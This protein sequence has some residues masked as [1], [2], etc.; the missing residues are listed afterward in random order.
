MEALRKSRSSLTAETSGVQ[1]SEVKENEEV[2]G[3]NNEL[4]IVTEPDDSSVRNS[5]NSVV[6]EECEVSEA[7]SQKHEHVGLESTESSDNIS[8]YLDKE[9]RSPVKETVLKT[10]DASNDNAEYEVIEQNPAT[11][12]SNKKKRKASVE[13]SYSKIKFEEKSPASQ[14]KEVAALKLLTK[15]LKMKQDLKNKQAEQQQFSSDT[16]EDDENKLKE[17]Q[18]IEENRKEEELTII[19]NEAKSEVD[20]LQD[21]KENFKETT[22][23]SNIDLKVEIKNSDS[24]IITNLEEGA[25]PVE[26]ISDE[27]TVLKKSLGH[28][29][30]DSS[31]NKIE[32]RRDEAEHSG[33]ETQEEGDGGGNKK[34]CKIRRT[35]TKT[36]AI[37]RQQLQQKK[38]VKKDP[39]NVKPVYIYIPLKPPEEEDLPACQNE[40]VADSPE[41]P[42]KNDVQ[43]IILTAPS[44]DEVLDYHSSDVPETPSSENKMF[45]E[46]KV[47]EL[48]KIAKEAVNEVDPSSTSQKLNTVAEETL[49]ETLPTTDEP[50]TEPTT[51]ETHSDNIEDELKPVQ[52]ETTTDTRKIQDEND[53]GVKITVDVED[54][55]N[56]TFTKKNDR[57]H[58]RK[59]KSSDKIKDSNKSGSYED[60]APPNLPQTSSEPG[61]EKDATDLLEHDVSH[62]MN[63]EEQVDVNKSINSH[64]DNQ[65]D[66]SKMSDHEY[67]P[68]NPPPDIQIVVSPTPT[69]NALEGISPLQS[70]DKYPDVLY[71]KNDL[72]LDDKQSHIQKTDPYPVSQSDTI[73]NT[74][75][76]PTSN[77]EPTPDTI[78]SPNKFQ[79]SWKQTTNNFK[80]R[81][82]NMK[83]QQPPAPDD[84]SKPKS[85][86]FKFERPKFNLA[87][88]FPDRSKINLPSLPSF[89]LPRRNSAKRSLKE[90]QQSTESNVS[91]SKKKSFDFSTYPRIFKK[92]SKPADE[93]KT[94]LDLATD[95][96]LIQQENDNQNS[97]P[98]CI[99][100]IPLNS[101]VSENSDENIE[102]LSEPDIEN[103][104]NDDKNEYFDDQ[105]ASHIRYKDDIDN[106]D[107]FESQIINKE[108]YLNRWN[109]GNFNC[110]ID[111]DYRRRYENSRFEVTDL[112][113]PDDMDQQTFDFTLN[114][115]K[116]TYSSGSSFGGQRL[117][118]VLEEIN[119]D[120]FFLRKKGISQDNIEVGMY[121]SSEIKEAFR[122]PDNALSKMEHRD[123]SLVDS[124]ISLPETRSKRKEV[125]KPKRKKTPHVSP[126]RISPD[127]SDDEDVSSSS[128]PLRPKRR[129]KRY[130]ELKNSENI[131]P[132]QETVSVETN[133]SS[134]DLVAEDTTNLLN[135]RS[136]D[137]VTTT[138]GIALA[139]DDLDFNYIDENPEDKP[140]APPRKHKSLKSLT[141][142]NDS[143]L[144][145]IATNN[146]LNKRRSEF[147]TSAT[148]PLK[149]PSRSKLKPNR[150]PDS[151]LKSNDNLPNEEENDKPFTSED[152]IPCVEEPCVQDFRDY[153]GYAVIDKQHA[154][155][156]PPLPPPRSPG[157]K[158]RSIET[159]EM[160]PL[161]NYSTLGQTR[162]VNGVE[163][164]DVKQEDKENIDNIQ[165]E[166]TEDGYNKDLQS[167]D[168]IK[169]MKDRPLPAPPRPPRKS[170]IL[171]N[172]TSQENIMSGIRTSSEDLSQAPVS[173]DE[174]QTD[175]QQFLNETDIL[176][177]NITQNTDKYMVERHLITPSYFTHEE[178]ITHGSLLVQSLTGDKILQDSDIT[179]SDRSEEKII[180]VSNESDNETSSIPEDFKM[181]KDPHPQEIRMQVTPDVNKE[182]EFLKAQKLHVIGLDVDTLTVS[183][184]LADKLIVSEIDSHNIQTDEIHSKSFQMK[185]DFPKSTYEFKPVVTENEEQLDVSEEHDDC[186]E[187]KLQRTSSIVNEDI[188]HQTNSFNMDC[189]EHLQTEPPVPPPRHLPVNMEHLKDDSQCSHESSPQEINTEN[190]GLNKVIQEPEVDDVPPPRPPQPFLDYLPSQPPASFYAYKAQKEVEASSIPKVP[191]RRRPIRSRSRS[192]SDDSLVTPIS[193]RYNSRSPE[194][195]SISHLSGQLASAC[196][197]RGHNALKRLIADITDTV[198]KNTDGKLDLHVMT[199]IL[200]ILVAGL[201]L[202]DYGVEKTVVHLH[203][204][205]Y[206][207]PPK[208]L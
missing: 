153:M 81:I 99:Q 19:N 94:E 182:I 89:N 144:E 77:N 55:L 39:Q 198:R 14:E 200:L 133:V 122:T 170:R 180:P 47:E 160:R 4:Q 156:S 12:E 208:D 29:G 168:I 134:E 17:D 187:K 126:E 7:E 109:R 51:E 175:K 43:L 49:S 37:H 130:R 155:R 115:N 114:Q 161:R 102:R 190:I 62:S 173:S 149:K 163:T 176:E 59:K 93:K 116:E 204:W 53:N 152:L 70:S 128:P 38:F 184:L 56:E 125:K 45:F 73:T 25:N 121:L 5:I 41:S 177:S 157:R 24:E 113:S 85:V 10:A 167:G 63:G 32:E 20:G 42:M 108:D 86:K 203:H 52:T 158:K 178:T 148:Y 201:I 165:Y 105:M 48:K 34:T 101:D 151:I 69:E 35:K 124:N 132:Y 110:D 188:E 205:E 96:R 79:I 139:S 162:K 146:E 74:S 13:S 6:I 3:N 189:S 159:A 199:I 118:G 75:S 16:V 33:V 207:N 164:D 193:R 194:E 166:G 87:K 145:D 23:K 31:G 95:S 137:I 15:R 58:S 2:K 169:R 123:S 129:S 136:R 206:F 18:N 71:K 27:D 192:S 120:E 186:E 8:Q 64:E 68:I 26:K 106:D 111:T 147:V 202:L 9:D 11:S 181:M 65:E 40:P 22:D 141:S 174:L 100:R 127:E 50:T 112:D 78:K 36:K 30:A 143:I 98:S 90:R 117:G 197:S 88:K 1:I 104:E 154:R 91:D 138:G 191:R 97:S 135:N 83:K 21:K 195:P 140:A 172:I 103:H 185:L 80:N 150:Q 84:G 179:H 67:E 119:P 44:D 54:G 76:Q 107:E 61:Q 66:W 82:R 171:Q 142:E 131:I 196:V 60:I 183:K 57:D 46:T 28:D 92:K 72:P